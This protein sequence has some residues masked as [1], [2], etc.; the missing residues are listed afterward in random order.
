MLYTAL[1][2]VAKAIASSKRSE[3]DKRGAVSVC[4]SKARLNDTCRK[5]TAS[6][7]KLQIFEACN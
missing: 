6:L 5:A 4:E 7:R 1:E 3:W 2:Y